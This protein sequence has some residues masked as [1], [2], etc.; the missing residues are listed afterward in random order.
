MYWRGKEKLIVGR[1]W[2]INGWDELFFVFQYFFYFQLPYLPEFT[3]EMND[4]K[5]LS[6][7]FKVI[8]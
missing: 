4:Y 7:A 5:M 3:I 1:S 6:M 8:P 2:N